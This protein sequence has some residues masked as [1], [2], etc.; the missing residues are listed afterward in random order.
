MYEMVCNDIKIEVWE[1]EDMLCRFWE[2]FLFYGVVF[3]K[4]KDVDIFLKIVQI[5][6]LMEQLKSFFEY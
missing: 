3:E 4:E 1:L 2:L 6:C 5:Y